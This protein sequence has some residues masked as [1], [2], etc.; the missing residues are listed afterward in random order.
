MFSFFSRF[1]LHLI[2]V[3]GEKFVAF[4]LLISA[5]PSLSCASS[6]ANFFEDTQSTWTTLAPSQHSSTST[7]CPCAYFP[8]II[9]H[10]ESH[11]PTPSS[12]EQVS[13]RQEQEWKGTFSENSFHRRDSMRRPCLVKVRFSTTVLLY[14]RTK[15]KF[16][17]GKL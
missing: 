13:I 14:K 16:V 4:R 17:S 1:L 9:R 7:V 11:A 5:S 6:G 12:A 15:I 2:S 8:S 10:P 3:F